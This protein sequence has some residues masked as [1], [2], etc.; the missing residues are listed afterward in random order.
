[1]MMR[2]KMLLHNIFS[3][4][5]SLFRTFGST[6]PSSGKKNPHCC[7]RIQNSL[8]GNCAN[9]LGGSYFS[10]QMVVLCFHFRCTKFTVIYSERNL[11]IQS[12]MIKI[13]RRL[14]RAISDI[15]TNR[16]QKRLNS[17][18]TNELKRIAGQVYK[19]KFG[20]MEEEKSISI[21]SNHDSHKSE[22]PVRRRIEF[23]TYPSQHLILHKPDV[24][25]DL[26]VNS[27][28]HSQSSRR[29][30]IVEKLQMR[31]PISHRTH[32]FINKIYAIEQD[33]VGPTTS[34]PLKEECGELKRILNSGVQVKKVDPKI[35]SELSK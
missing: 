8:V 35:F 27:E 5:I 13:L 4:F 18:I 23:P 10:A 21:K 12:I 17:S 19:N 9:S 31:S 7:F 16:S 28:E 30:Q 24:Y 34:T 3:F 32:C 22:R 25:E 6:Q 33:Q 15:Q 26:R 29:R 14:Q 1:M 20:V 2:T 11:S